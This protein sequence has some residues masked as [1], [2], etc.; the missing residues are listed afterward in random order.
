M[1]VGTL[2]VSGNSNTPLSSNNTFAK[3]T[4]L[5]FYALSD[6]FT[7]VNAT[8]TG[9]PTVVQS[10]LPPDEEV[11]WEGT[12][13]VGADHFASYHGFGY[14]AGSGT[15]TP[16]TF[17]WNGESVT[18]TQLQYAGNPASGLSL[19][20]DLDDGDGDWSA[21]AGTAAVNLYL[22]DQG[23]RIDNPGSRTGKTYIGGHGLDW[24]KGQQVRARLTVAENNPPPDLTRGAVVGET[25]TVDLTTIDEP[26][27]I[28]DPSEVAF[29]WSADGVDIDG[30]TD[31][32]Y[33]P[34]PADVGKRIAVTV[35]F[36]DG[37]GT[38]EGPLTSDPETV[39]VS[40]LGDVIWSTVMTV[41]E[42]GFAGA[43]H[44]GYSVEE[45]TGSLGVDTFTFNS[46]EFTV[47][48]LYFAD[49]D[50]GADG[51]SLGTDASLGDGVF[52]LHLNGKAFLFQGPPRDYTADFGY[53]YFDF[54]YVNPGLLWADGDQVEVRLV[55][56]FNNEPTGEPVITG[57]DPPQVGERLTADTSA[58]TD[59]DGL[60]EPE[61]FTY[62]WVR[63]GGQLRS[64]HRRLHRGRRW[65]H[66]RPEGGRHRPHPLC[67]GQLHGQS[68]LQG[69]RDQPAHHQRRRPVT[70]RRRHLVR[71]D[72]RRELQL[73]W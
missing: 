9:K 55:T 33:R 52:F 65:R 2:D 32:A 37:G 70:L 29:Q 3:A 43:T 59:D 19:R 25:L 35:S 23:F 47:L 16:A 12:I 39:A 26:D 67:R 18:V 21:L 62:Q 68:G 63:V 73:F 72:D 61:E 6:V 44:Y 31:P 40:P 17:L 22:D 13:T 51:L 10:V 24:T 64:H 4:T 45:R 20:F 57:D 71:Q 54:S 42:D 53:P 14:P 60:P 5:P 36:T 7:V 48:D 15:L 27:G 8:A 50:M 56:A 30:A 58:V 41:A 66:L 11:I 28:P 34:R 69:D 46:V 38:D 49:E 1:T